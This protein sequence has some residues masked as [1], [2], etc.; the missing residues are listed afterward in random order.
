MDLAGKVVVVTGAGVAEETGA[1]G[2]GVNL[3][4]PAAVERPRIEQVFEGQARSTGSSVS[5]VRALFEGLSTLARD[6]RAARGLAREVD[7]NSV[8][9]GR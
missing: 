6:R 2:I 3:I 5:E 8:G 1:Y 9:G 4:S 7:D